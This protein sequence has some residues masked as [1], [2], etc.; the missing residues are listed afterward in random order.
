MQIEEGL[1]FHLASLAHG[2][3]LTSTQLT[4]I[5]QLYPESQSTPLAKAMLRLLHITEQT[6]ALG[7]KGALEDTLGLI[8]Q[9][10]VGK[11]KLEEPLRWLAAC[12]FDQFREY[13]A[14][15]QDN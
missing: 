2:T 9:G 7:G 14:R 6:L 8:L 1:A 15:M 11:L 5:I 13:C 3:P 10:F 4:H 12:E